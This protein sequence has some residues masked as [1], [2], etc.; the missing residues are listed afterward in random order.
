MRFKTELNINLSLFEKNVQSLQGISKN[1]EIIFMVKSNGYGHGLLEMSQFSVRE[2]GINSLGVAS[3]GEA[4]KLRSELTEEKFDLYTFSELQ[5]ESEDLREHYLNQR[6]LPVIHNVNDLET[7]LTDSRFSHCPLVLHFNTGMNRLGVE[8]N[9]T[10]LV[11]KKIKASGRNSVSHLMSHFG[12]ASNSMSTNSHNKRQLQNWDTLKKELRGSGINIEQTSISNSGALEQGVGLEESHIR[13]GLMLYG[14][15][16][17]IPPLRKDSL[18]KGQNISILKTEVLKVFKVERGQPIG[19]GATPCP[20]AGYV[21]VIALGYGDGF[22]T[23]Y[24][25]ANI[26]EARIHGRVNMDMAQLFYKTDPKLKV[27]DQFEVWGNSMESIMSFS[28]ETKTIPY[29]LFCSLTQRVP[30][31]YNS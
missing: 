1:N 14:P 29:E 4:I 12:C 27:G 26:G 31:T 18:W 6:I 5:F 13:P 21:V 22:S 30:R 16:S 9:E 2:T 24:C 25:G 20:E 3:L 19:Y 10:E 17:L 15:S 8:L 28:D 23:K 7:F 11:I